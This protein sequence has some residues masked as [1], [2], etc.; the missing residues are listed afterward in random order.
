MRKDVYERNFAR[1]SK[2]IP[3]L[4]DLKPGDA[5]KSR[6]PGFMD[7]NLD[8]LSR[9]ENKVI[10]GDVKLR[11]ALA[12][13][14]IQE[15]DVMADPDMEIAVYISPALSIVEALTF[16]QDSG[17]PTYSVVYPE[18]GKVNLAAKQYLNEFLETWLCNLSQQGHKL[19]KETKTE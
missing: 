9:E 10:Q 3:D 7:L 6:S 5:R 13:N 16:Q 18:P 17:T 19:T 4:Q 8:V 12:H 11:L 15:G 1:L 14:Y 2:L